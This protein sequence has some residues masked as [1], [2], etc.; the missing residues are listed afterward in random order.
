MNIAA[1]VINKAVAVAVTKAAELNMTEEQALRFV[2][3]VLKEAIEDIAR[4]HPDVHR[5]FAA[6]LEAG[7]AADGDEDAARGEVRAALR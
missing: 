5:R 1:T 3:L 2:G 7:L 6:S 4:N